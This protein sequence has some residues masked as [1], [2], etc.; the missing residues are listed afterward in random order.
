MLKKFLFLP[1]ILSIL[2]ISCT[3]APDGK[4]TLVIESNTDH[5][6]IQEVYARR[7]GDSYYSVVWTSSNFGIKWT[8][9]NINL[10]PGQYHIYVKMCYYDTIY[11]YPSTGIS[12]V[13]INEGQTK[14]LYVR[15][16]SLYQ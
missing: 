8:H 2:F 5:Y 4:G 6:T 16:L 7:V 14:F 1:F 9:A 15:N 10:E 13:F 11:T 12:T 3:Q